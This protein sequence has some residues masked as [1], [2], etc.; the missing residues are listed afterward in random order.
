MSSNPPVADGLP[1][2]TRQKLGIGVVAKIKPVSQLAAEHQVSRKFVYQQGQKA[3][4][5]LDE[6]FEL[7][8]SEDADCKN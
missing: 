3:K 5:A 2:N 4:A 6:V 1:P 8:T 7:K